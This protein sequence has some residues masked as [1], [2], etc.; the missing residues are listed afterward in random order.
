M[1]F[2]LLTSI[3]L[4]T[5]RGHDKFA[6]LFLFAEVVGM[7]RLI[8]VEDARRQ[9]QFNRSEYVCSGDFESNAVVSEDFGAVYDENMNGGD[10]AVTDLKSASW[11]SVA[12]C[13]LDVRK[14]FCRIQEVR[15][16]ADADDPRNLL[17]L[18]SSLA[19]ESVVVLSATITQ[20]LK[21][22]KA[23]HDSSRGGVSRFKNLILASKSEMIMA[24]NAFITKASK[25]KTCFRLWRGP[26]FAISNE[27]CPSSKLFGPKTSE[28]RPA[29]LPLISPSNITLFNGSQLVQN[30]PARIAG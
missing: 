18:L 25:L 14:W 23:Q 17:D 4:H 26:V 1:L 7:K 21:H 9:K 12:V 24:L 15:P 5:Q 20:T 29:A 19:K 22:F 2:V 11:S 28:D 27:S 8:C 16:D 10:W 6:E 30:R 13:T 3:V